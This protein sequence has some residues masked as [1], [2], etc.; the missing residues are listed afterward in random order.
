MRLNR[1]FLLATIL[2]SFVKLKAQ[3]NPYN[4][5]SISSPTAASLGKYGDIPVN[6]HTGIPQISI[7][8]Y[9]IKEGPLQMPISL[10]YHGGGMKVHELPSWVGAGW[11]LNAG[12]VITR[13][14][15]GAPDERGTSNVYDQTHGHFSDYGY[16]S[17]LWVA[18]QGGIGYMQDWGKIADGRKDG[19]PDLFFFNFA[20]YS[21][22][23]Y[24]HD[25]RTPMLVP[26]QDIKISYNYTGTGSIQSFILTTPDGTQ[27]HFGVT[28]S[29]TDVDP[30]EQSDPYSGGAFASG[31]V[32]SSWYLSKIVSADGKFSISL[33]YV[34]EKYSY[35]ILAM[36]PVSYLSQID[37][38]PTN[39][40]EYKLMKNFVKGVRLSSISFSNGQVNFIPN[41]SPREDLCAYLP[42][43]VTPEYLNTEAKALAE[44]HVSNNGANCKKFVLSTGYFID[45]STALAGYFSTNNVN[46]DKKRLKLQSIQEQSC[47]GASVAPPHTFEYFAEL[48]PRR[49]SFGLDHWGF[50]NGITTNT[51]LI[52]TYSLLNEYRD[53]TGADR[54]AS[55]PAM[56]GGALK[57]IIYPTGGH[58]EFEFEPNYTWVSYNKYQWTGRFNQTAGYDGS[59]NPV[60][61]YQ[62]FSGGVYKIAFT[63]PSVGSQALLTIRDSVTNAE[64]DGWVLEPGQSS[65]YIRQYTAGTYKVVLQKLSAVSGNGTSANFEEWVTYAIQKNDTV[66][67]LRIKAITHHDGI[68]TQN[69]MVTSFSYV[70]NG[71]STGI[72]YSRPVYVSKLR[73]DILRD[74]GYEWG[75]HCDAYGCTSCSLTGSYYKSPSGIRPMETTQGNHIGYNEVKVGQTGNGYSVYRYY[76]SNIWDLNNKDVAQRTIDATA[77]DANVPNAPYPPVPHEYMRGELKYEGHFKEG[78]QLLKEVEYYPTFTENPIATPALMVERSPILNLPSYGHPFS[79]GTGAGPANLATF[80]ELK[81]AKKTQMKVVE[82][83][84]VS[85]TLMTTAKTIHFASAY[86]NQPTSETM[87]TSGDSIETRYKYANDFRISSCDTISTCYPAY[88]SAENTCLSQYNAALAACSSQSCRWWAW[89]AYIKCKSD[90]RITFTNC[91]KAKF[92]N[93]ANTFDSC[94]QST[95][96]AADSWLKPILELQ[97]LYSNPII[98]ATKWRGVNLLEASFHKFDYST[99]PSNKVYLNRILEINLAVPS[100][101]FTAASNTSTTITKDSR[102][103]DESSVKFYEGNLVE[104]VPKNGLS[105]SYIWGHNN[106][107]PIVK[108]VGATHSTL[109]TAYDAVGGNLSQIRSQS[110]LQSALVSTYTYSP[111]IGMTSETD[112]AGRK[113]SYEYD[114]L[115]RLKLI[116]DKDSNIVKQFAY[117][118]RAFAHATPVWEATGTTRCKPCPLNTNYTSDTLQNQERDVNAES[119]TYNQTRWTN[120]G[121]SGMCIEATWENTLTATRCKKVNGLNTGE[122]EQEQKDMNP[123]SA[124]YNSTRWIAI[125]TD[126]VNCG[127]IY[128]VR[129]YENYNY[130]GYDTYSDVVLYFYQ[131]AA[132]TIPISL[133]NFSVTVKRVTYVYGY[134]ESESTNAITCNGYSTVVQLQAARHVEDGF[135]GYESNNYF[136]IAGTGYIP[137]NPQ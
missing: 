82:K 128:A 108:A 11:A 53:E 92:T 27:Y 16:N 7:P 125:G 33:S 68:S 34:T 85:S 20:G 38:D 24:F 37:S 75:T 52:P 111:I 31:L 58:T 44:I 107:L 60:I 6:Y 73:N 136:V 96:A 122:Q 51:Q 134:G 119:P 65:Q 89:Q 83:T 40:F 126:T 67:G 8:I 50:Y 81:T 79:G 13:T 113:I 105:T 103:E 76:G 84:T 28:P 46:T 109:K 131:D 117:G 127:P 56:R 132:C 110:S 14:V 19:E 59:S 21:G 3:I 49:L 87:T 70:A 120:V 135:G 4:E 112:P 100:T 98:E 45:T 71:R 118:Y 32:T 130:F 26:E 47:D 63:N 114:A 90:A 101:T 15:Q 66:G 94:K 77:C 115:Q 12:G 88:T 17:D 121:P 42:L 97:A 80:Y 78:G 55:W 93:P 86:H 69:D 123:C 41:S 91:R 133:T 5:I 102:Y 124:T 35:Y 137:L 10:S 72:L 104:I 39:D 23:F 57:K 22:K 95:L 9:T 30:I 43:T 116:R 1:L 18:Y 54:D 99:N 106:T 74:I 25:D 2:L 48:A 36:Y 129:V 62:S 61:T 64:I 29:S